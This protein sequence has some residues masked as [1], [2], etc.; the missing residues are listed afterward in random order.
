M[1]DSNPSVTVSVFN[2]ISHQRREQS[3]L[4]SSH[5]LLFHWETSGQPSR[6][7]WREC[8]LSQGT[9]DTPMPNRSLN[10]S[11]VSASVWEGFILETWNASLNSSFLFALE[12]HPNSHR[13]P[14]PFCELL[15]T[16]LS[17]FFC[18]L[19]LFA[20]ARC[21][22]LPNRCRACGFAATGPP[23]LSLTAVKR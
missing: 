12:H 23:S 19:Q 6:C 17:V 2:R 15:R 11:F 1:K 22:C 20:E 18:S 16:E 21:G 13:G 4:C 5:F 3:P 8:L 7:S 9:R 14:N 10:V